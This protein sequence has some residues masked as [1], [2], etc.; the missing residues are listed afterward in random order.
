MRRITADLEKCTGCRTCELVCSFKRTG[1]FNPKKSAIRI[2][3]DNQVGLDGPI[4]CQL[5]RNP[6]CV[7]ACPEG[8]LGKDPALGVITVDEIKCNGCRLCEEACPFGAVTFHPEANKPIICNLCGGKPAC[9]EWCDTG[10]LALLSPESSESLQ[11]KRRKT[12]L[13]EFI[14]ILEKWGIVLNEG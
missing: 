6:H 12:A 14:P 3:K 5:C 4:T 2:V 8:A 11:W 7:E 10:A 13:E 1:A 9:V